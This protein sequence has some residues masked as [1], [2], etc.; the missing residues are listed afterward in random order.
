MKT[1]KISRRGFL[2]SSAGVAAALTLAPRHVLGGARFV[3]PSEKVNIAI[4]GAGGQGR[5]NVRA[6]FQQADAQVIAVCDPNERANYDEYYYKGEAG[7]RPVRAEIEAHYAA[8]TPNYR[9]A[10]YEDFRVLFERERA[11]DALLC[12]TPDHLH[13][14]V[15]IRAMRMGKHVYCEKPLTHSVAEARAVAR[16]ARETG[17]ATQMGNQGHS[18]DGIRTTCEWIW[19]G[20]IG[21]VREVHGW[22]G[23]A[24]WFT[25]RGLPADRPPVPAGLNWDLWLGP[26]QPRPYHPTYAPVKWRS[27]WE[28]G[29]SMIGDMACHNLDPAVWALDLHAPAH[30][31]ACGSQVDPVTTPAGGIYR[32]QFG[33]RGQQP[34]VK[35]VWYDGGL[36]PERPADLP[37]EDAMGSNGVLF[38]GDRGVLMCPGWGGPP[39]LLPEARMDAYRRP[40]K[41]L[42]RSKGHHRD[43]LDACKGGPPA[44]ASFE[45]GARITELV[46]LGN[47]AMRAGKRIDW[48]GAAMKATNAP[49]ADQYLHSSYRPGWE[50]ES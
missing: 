15:C 34:P 27:Y 43:W 22:T 33:T 45:Y 39:T 11:I 26:R 21:P 32:F 47:V 40:P 48:D 49:E 8:R 14:L 46:L 28:F 9:C 29:T 10:E 50:L 36:R 20:A 37:E 38:I 4:V 25:H 19:D 44:S 5:A 31:E 42:P 3:P 7:R 41:T 17:V 35:V 18:G 13:A 23:A 16:V 12:A 1:A 30:V 24:K 6:L 2:R